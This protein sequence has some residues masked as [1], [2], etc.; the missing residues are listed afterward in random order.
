M[1]SGRTGQWHVTGEISGPEHGLNEFQSGAYINGILYCLAFSEEGHQAILAYNVEKEEWS[2]DWKCSYPR[3]YLRC[4]DR[5]TNPQLLRCGEHVYFFWEETGDRGPQVSQFRI[6]RLNIPT[7]DSNVDEQ[8]WSPVVS[9][10]RKGG[11]GLLSYP[12]YTCSSSSP[13]PEDLNPHL[14]V[15]NTISHTADVYDVAG[16]AN[17][18]PIKILEPP[19][20]KHDWEPFYPLNPVAFSFEPSF[21]VGVSRDTEI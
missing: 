6:A 4:V 19:R 17:P 9:H 15:F 14:C 8:G 3:E 21:C 5:A 2:T 10:V 20:I 7:D 18:T 16:K 11:N 12:E 1:R 13:G